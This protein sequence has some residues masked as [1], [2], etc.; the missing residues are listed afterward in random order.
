MRLSVTEAANLYR[1]SRTTIYRNINNG[2]LS[3]DSD[4]K[5]DLSEMIRVFGEAKVPSTNLVSQESAPL[6]T[7]LQSENELM[8]HEKI[9]GLELQVKTLQ[10]QLE[11]ANSLIEWFKNQVERPQKLIEHKPKKSLF[12]RVLSAINNE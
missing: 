11:N 10:S 2:K 9:R 3:T 5:I 12:N 8:L 4:N 7:P 6:V 1:I